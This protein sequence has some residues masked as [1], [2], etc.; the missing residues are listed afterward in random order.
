MRLGEELMRCCEVLWLAEITYVWNWLRFNGLIWTS[1]RMVTT[2]TDGGQG[3]T[4]LWGRVLCNARRRTRNV[5]MCGKCTQMILSAV[6]ITCCMPTCSALVPLVNHTVT[7]HNGQ[8]QSK[9]Y[10]HLLWRVFLVSSGRKRS[11]PDD[12]LYSSS[13]FYFHTCRA[14]QQV[15]S[16]HR[17]TRH[18][19]TYTNMQTDINILR[20]TV[21]SF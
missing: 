4:C 11:F 12:R 1:Y 6:L 2:A 14:P 18:N 10:D 20:Q 9:V 19:K 21:F 13:S 17:F 3:V 16:L 15:P 7:Q 8:L 5:L